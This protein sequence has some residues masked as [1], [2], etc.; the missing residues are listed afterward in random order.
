MRPTLITDDLDISFN[1][2]GG[3]PE[4]TAAHESV[5]PLKHALRTRVLL[6][7]A[8]SGENGLTS[9]DVESMLGLRHQSASARITEL[10]AGNMIEPAEKRPTRSGRTAQAWKAT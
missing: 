8:G 3:N 10:R 4:S 7:I 9:D 1:K 2:H 5:V 6:A